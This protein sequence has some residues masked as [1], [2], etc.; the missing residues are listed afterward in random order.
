MD[1][2]DIKAKA[3][4]ALYNITDNEINCIYIATLGGVQQLLEALKIPDWNAV[5]AAHTYFVAVV[6]ASL[7]EP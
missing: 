1:D 7:S 5:S 3:A 6:R 4:E 2:L